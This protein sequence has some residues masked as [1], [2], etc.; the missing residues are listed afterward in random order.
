MR[1]IGGHDY[2][3]SSLAYG[4]DEDLI[5]LRNDK[6]VPVKDCPLVAAYPLDIIAP[7]SKHGYW[8]TSCE[9]NEK[10]NQYQFISISVYAAGKHYGGVK[11]EHKNNARITEEFFWD[12]TKLEEFINNLGRKVN[13][14]KNDWL[15]DSKAD[16][17]RQQFPTLLSWMT[18]CDI[19]EKQLEWIINNKVAIAINTTGR[20]HWN[21]KQD[22][23]HINCATST[24][25][26]KSIDFAK[27]VDPYTLFQELSMF[28][29][30]V[31]PRDANPMVEITDDK[32]K[33]A[34]HGFDKW[35]FRKHKEDNL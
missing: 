7:K 10:D 6:T 23:W 33:I 18:P 32:I 4:R 13:D 28:I 9:I 15:S 16:Y 14:Y 2:Y 31:L 1:L 35:T 24:F 19:N 27:V 8:S 30:G 11:V 20:W 22:D 29:G 26:L 21:Q 12:Y 3:D 5:F 34:K 25:S 17:D